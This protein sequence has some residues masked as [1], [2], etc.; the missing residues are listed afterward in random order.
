MMQ[1]F[2]L[3]RTTLRNVNKKNK[4]QAYSE[5][6]IFFT[7]GT[8]MQNAALNLQRRESDWAVLMAAHRLFQNFSL[9]TVALE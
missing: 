7:D 2:N 4:Y 3:G 1:L 8:T 9:K 5:E 6:Y